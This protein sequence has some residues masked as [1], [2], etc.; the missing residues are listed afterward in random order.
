MH[1]VLE[2]SIDRLPQD[3]RGGCVGT[4]R[5]AS[6]MTRL[7]RR[8]MPWPWV[9][10]GAHYR[11]SERDSPCAASRTRPS[12]SKPSP[13]L[14]GGGGG[15]QGQGWSESK[16]RHSSFLYARKNSTFSWLY[17]KLGTFYKKLN[18]E[19]QSQQI[20]AYNNKTLCNIKDL[21][22]NK[23]KH[24]H[25]VNHICWNHSFLPFPNADIHEISD[26]Y[27]KRQ[28]FIKNYSFL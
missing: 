24:K 10:P 19:W 17:K 13:T 27:Q 20:C 8:Q 15:D 26:F 28:L 2:Y 14:P 9:N 21:Y 1:L 18:F 6:H 22:C 16:V 12:P 5:A 4:E 25:M 11:V 23:H 3:L 7:Y